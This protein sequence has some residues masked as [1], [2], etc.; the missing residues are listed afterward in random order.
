MRKILCI[1]LGG[2]FLCAPAI[3]QISQN[4]TAFIYRPS[5]AVKNGR[6]TNTAITNGTATTQAILDNTTFISSDAFV[7]SE[8]IRSKSTIPLNI[9]GGTYNFES[10]GS[11]LTVVPFSSGGVLSSF[12]TIATAGTGYAVGDVFIVQA[13]NRNAFVVVN[14]IGAGGSVPA[15]GDLTILYGGT[16]YI[17][18]GSPVAMFVSQNAGNTFTLTGSLSS[19]ALFILNTSSYIAGGNQLV[20]NNNTTGAYTVQFKTS[21]GADGSIGTGVFIPQGASN[22]CATFIQKDGVNDIWLAAPSVCSVAPNYFTGTTASIGG[23]LLT[24][25]TCTSGTASVAGATTSMG[26]VATPVTYP[27]DGSTWLAYVSSA[28][29]VTVEVCALIAVTPTASAYNVRVIQ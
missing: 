12:L 18:G 21:D 5:I 15:T 3:A 20:V 11:G 4:T 2:L 19:N 14:T 24:A 8:I 6:G 17:T 7:N 23:G 25:G 13:G 26:V 28:G 22:S 9:T 16:G 27:G 29:T 10:L 1:I